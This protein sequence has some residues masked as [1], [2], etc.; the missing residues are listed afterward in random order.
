MCPQVA[1]RAVPA[2]AHIAGERF[3]WAME[4]QVSFQDLC[5]GEAL[6]TL[7]AGVSSLPAV[8]QL[9]AFQGCGGGEVFPT[10]AAAV[11]PDAAVAPL[12]NQKCTALPEA[13][14]AGIADECPL[15]AV[16][17]AVHL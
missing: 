5:V 10:L 3:V 16:Q 8:H 11:W 14:P 6:P 4:L 17:S 1:Q 7:L 15:S 2:A 13:L 12:M 9:V